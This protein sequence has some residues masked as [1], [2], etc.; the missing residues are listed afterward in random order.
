MIRRLCLL[1]DC[2][3]ALSALKRSTGRSG[4]HSSAD[5][6]RTGGD[7]W[8]RA[9]ARFRKMKWKRVFIVSWSGARLTDLV[10]TGW[11][12]FHYSLPLIWLGERCCCW[13]RRGMGRFFSKSFRRLQ[14]ACL[15]SACKWAWLK[16]IDRPDR[17]QLVKYFRVLVGF[18]GEK[19][20]S[21]HRQV[22][23]NKDTQATR[24]SADRREGTVRKQSRRNQFSGF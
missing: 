6:H 5:K 19:Q 2:L 22:H 12:V 16:A 15:A 4:G 17:D 18:K 20:T 13:R 9:V 1:P 21:E 24:K 23:T 8:D 10:K 14:S 7:T 3:S 11:I